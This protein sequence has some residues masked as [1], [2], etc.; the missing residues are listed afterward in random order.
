MDITVQPM[1]ASVR[2]D[3]IEGFLREAVQSLGASWDVDRIVAEVV[4]MAHRHVAGRARVLVA[5]YPEQRLL[6]R[7]D[8][9]ER[10]VTVQ[11]WEYLPVAP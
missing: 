1:S 2:H 11:E 4:P 3:E 8:D 5:R 10:H 7:L 6:V 9:D